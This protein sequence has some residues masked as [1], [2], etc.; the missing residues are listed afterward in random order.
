MPGKNLTE[1]ECQQLLE[2]LLEG[3]NNG[4]LER[5]RLLLAAERFSVHR[6]TTCR[7]WSDWLEKR[8]SQKDHLWDTTSKRENSGRPKILDK[9]EVLKA[10]SKLEESARSTL[11]S[12]AVELGVSHA[13][14]NKLAK[15]GLIVKSRRKMKP[16]LTEEAKVARVL[17]CLNEQDRN[18]L[19]NNMEDRIHVGEKWFDLAKV[20]QSHWCTDGEEKKTRRGQA[21]NKNKM[22]KLIFLAAVG[23]PQYDFGQARQFDRKVGIWPLAC[24]V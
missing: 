8:N 20:V 6:S 5:G 11:R 12:S 16:V 24:R 22:P 4:M 2:F 7:L 9:S 15:K 14:L 10:M 21:T 18:G 3:Y 19:Y 17:F 13:Y 1:S 23:R